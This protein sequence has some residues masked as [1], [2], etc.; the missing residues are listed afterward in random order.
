MKRRL[1]MWLL[2]LH[3]PNFRQR[4]GDEMLGIFDEVALTGGALSLLADAFVSLWRQWLL[5]PEFRTRPL[6]TASGG[7]SLDGVPAFPLCESGP[8]RTP[9][10]TAI[11]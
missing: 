1:Y 9:E 4:F 5:R 3:P 11:S 7:P 8:P 6:L 10:R 2:R